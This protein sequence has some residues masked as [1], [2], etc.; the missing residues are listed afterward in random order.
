M[1]ISKLDTNFLKDHENLDG[2]DIYSVLE[3]PISLHGIT[4]DKPNNCFVRLPYE[5]AKSISHP[6]EVLNTCTSGGR[7]RFSTD[8]KKIVIAVKYRYTPQSIISIPIIFLIKF[9][10]KTNIEKPIPNRIN[11]TIYI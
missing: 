5:L 9:L 11:D 7:A 3:A 10:W 2:K 4:F 8:S 1:D 6:L